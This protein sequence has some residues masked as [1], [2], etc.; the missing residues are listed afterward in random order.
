MGH[1]LCHQNSL[2][3]GVFLIQAVFFPSPLP[4]PLISQAAWVPDVLRHQQNVF[5]GEAKACAQHVLHALCVVDAAPQLRA[6]T[7]VVDAHD[8]RLLPGP[9]GRGHGRRDLT[10]ATDARDGWPAIRRR[11]WTG[12]EGR[13][14]CLWEGRRP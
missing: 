7:P 6:L 10:R 8:K 11:A 14:L 5:L 9:T 4:S 2:H 13:R 3:P 1:C 12:G